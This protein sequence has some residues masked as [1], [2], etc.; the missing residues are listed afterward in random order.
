MLASVELVGHHLPFGNHKNPSVHIDEFTVSMHIIQV[1]H[2]YRLLVNAE[3][4]ACYGAMCY[5]NISVQVFSSLLS[6]L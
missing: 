4:Y 6:G 2:A 5:M 1:Y 3:S